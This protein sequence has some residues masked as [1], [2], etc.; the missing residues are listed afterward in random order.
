M[1]EVN[2]NKGVFI[3]VKA[4]TTIHLGKLE[5]NLYQGDVVEFDGVTLRVGNQDVV[6]PELKSGIKRG[7]LTI[8]DPTEYVEE[9]K[10]VQPV[11]MPKKEMPVQKVYDEEK[12]VADVVKKEVVQAKKFPVQVESQ[13]DDVRPVHKV[14]NKSGATVSGASSAMDNVS[15]Q[16]GAEAVKIPLKTASKQKV[17]ISDGSQITKEMAKLE[18]LQRDAVKKPVVVVVEDQQGAEVL[19]ETVTIEETSITQEELS[20]ALSQ[21]EEVPASEEPSS[22][23]NL[24][25]IVEAMSNLQEDLQTVEALDAKPSTGAVIIGA[26]DEFAWDKSKHWQH[27]VKLAVEKYGNDPETLAKIKAIETD[28]VV[29]A[30]DK[31][32]ADQQ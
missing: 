23:L 26:G 3:R 1:S 31:A 7:W 32:L 24:D 11:V 18:N 15:S 10:A 14:D 16:Q 4:N 12:S 29:K 28:G 22:E 9:K 30:I 25:P 17:V 13:D 8:V 20:V 21:A 19:N 6:M 2:F 5:R 27:R